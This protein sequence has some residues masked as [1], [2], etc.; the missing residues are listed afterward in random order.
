ML[1]SILSLLKGSAMRTAPPL[2][3]IVA[4]VVLVFVI[5]TGALVL[6]AL[7]PTAARPDAWNAVASAGAAIAVAVPSLLAWLSA[8]SA[9]ASATSAAKA[10]NGGFESRVSKIVTSALTGAGLAPTTGTVPT[11]PAPVTAPAPVLTSTIANPPATAVAT[12][13]P[14]V[15]PDPPPVPVVAA[16]AVSQADIVAALQSLLTGA[17]PVAQPAAP[18]PAAVAPT[19]TPPGQ[20]APAVTV[21]GA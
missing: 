19:L 5:I 9:D 1:A 12:P 17:A 18:A 8:S 11:T 6:Y 20:A 16:P 4:I 13:V 21:A 7:T 10:L 2:R 15:V 3:S 14:V